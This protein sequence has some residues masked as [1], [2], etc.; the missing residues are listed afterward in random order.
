MPETAEQIRAAVLEQS[1]CPTCQRF[2]NSQCVTCSPHALRDPLYDRCPD[3]RVPGLECKQRTWFLTGTAA[4]HPGEGRLIIS[5]DTAALLIIGRESRLLAKAFRCEEH[6][7]H[8]ELLF[9][10]A[11]ASDTPVTDLAALCHR[12]QDS[13]KQQEKQT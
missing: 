11:L 1:W 13:L 3:A 12:L 9:L 4:S 10:H 7:C 2:E 8:D 5:A 6:I